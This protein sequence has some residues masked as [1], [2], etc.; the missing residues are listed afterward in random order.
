LVIKKIQIDLSWGWQARE[1]KSKKGAAIEEPFACRSRN[2]SAAKQQHL[3]L[4]S[5]KQQQL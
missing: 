1:D 5:V 3:D 4:G 2:A